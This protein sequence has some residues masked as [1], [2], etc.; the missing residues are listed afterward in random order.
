MKDSIHGRFAVNLGVL[1][2]AG[3][4]VLVEGEESVHQIAAATKIVYINAIS[5]PFRLFILR[6]RLTE[7]CLRERQGGYKA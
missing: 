5:V 3:V 2:V 1:H 6:V 7:G 4:G